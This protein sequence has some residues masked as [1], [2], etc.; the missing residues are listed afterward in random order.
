MRV[1]K[2]GGTSVANA[3]RFMRVADIIENNARQGQVATVLSAPAKITNHLVAMIDK[4]VSGQDI[5]PVMSESETIFAELLRGLALAQPGFAYDRLKAFVAHE[6]AQL[7]QQLHGIS[8][9]GQCPDSVNAAIICRG[10][11][12]S[13]AIMEAVFQ[14]KGYPVTVINPVEKLLA[15]GHYLE[16]TVDIAESTRRIVASG[17]PADHIIL[18][19]GFTA[20]ND[21]GELVVLGRNGSDYSAA[22]LAACLRADCCEIWTDVDGVYT[23]D[24]RTVPDARLLKSMSYQEAMELSY[25]GAKVL[26]P[27]TI[28]PIA[29][30][31]IPCLI[32]N[33]ANPQAPGTLI[34]GEG[35][36]DGYPVKGITNLN[37]MAMINVSGPGMKG[38]VG[39]AARV[40]AVMS[41]S[42]ISVV[43][44]TQSSSEYSISFC[45]PQGELL[46]ARKALEDEFYLELKDGVLDPLDVMERLAIISVVGDGMRTLRG[47]SARFFSALARAN[48]NIIAIAQGS[49]ERSISVVVNNDSVTTGVRVCHQMLF[50]TD[51]VIEVFV[52][53]AGGVGGAL[54]EQIHRQQPWLKQKHIDLRVCGI[55]NSKALLTNVHGIDLNNWQDQLAVAQE[56]FNLGRLIRLVKEYH[57][58][59]P[60]IV[61]CTS[62]QA[63]ADQYADFL[64]DG[65]HVVTPNKKANTSSMNYYRQLRTAAAKSSRKFLYDT[66]VGAGLPVIENLQNLLNAGDELLRFSGILSGSLSFIFGKL[67]EGMSL[68]EATLQAKSLGYTEPDPRDDLSGMDIARKLLILA[69]EA[70]YKLELTDIEVE[71][72]LPASFD[73]SGDVENFLKRLPSLDADFNRRVTNASEQG[74]VLRYVGVIEDGRCQVRMD[75][76]DGNDPLYK[77]KNGENALAF[78]TRYYQPIPLVLRGYGAGNDVTAAGVFADLLRTL[79]WK[80]GV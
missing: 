47:I 17:I 3:E 45:V 31:Q 32:K 40:F 72:V 80:L 4:T 66:N 39:M 57:L 38:M 54:I 10:E 35:M 51:Q 24:P 77:V 73:A 60:V 79:S 63:V 19:A 29:Q 44:I 42:G 69:R 6:F 26:H 75:A 49:S 41:R 37:N 34:G 71:S 76:V 30:F 70:G 36:D 50:N 23:C 52:I 78:Y 65:F 46:L 33:T 8:L 48:I 7:K 5:F 15:Q 68:S 20:G 14:A 25:F 62:S 58:L 13:I 59:N 16:S 27:R 18:M 56:P 28:A 21:K 55:A 12:M 74:K 43:L 9:L 22:V 11:K 1:L 61:D 67:D 53:G 64:S 2:F